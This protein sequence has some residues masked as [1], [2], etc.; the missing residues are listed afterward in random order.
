MITDVQCVHA[1]E[2]E[3]LGMARGISIQRATVLAAPLRSCARYL[4]GVQAADEKTAEAAAVVEFN[5]SD[6][7]RRRLVVR[8]RDCQQDRIAAASG[9]GGVPNMVS[10]PL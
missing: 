3:Q 6:E 10:S 8:E 4:G 2:C 7:Q 9:A 5:P 1:A